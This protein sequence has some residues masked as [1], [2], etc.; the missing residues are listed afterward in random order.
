MIA[1]VTGETEEDVRQALLSAGATNVMRSV[2][3]D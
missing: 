1:L 3:G 2:V